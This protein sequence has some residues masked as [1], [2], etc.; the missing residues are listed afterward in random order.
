MLFNTVAVPYLKI[1]RRKQGDIPVLTH[2][3]AESDCPAYYPVFNTL[4]KKVLFLS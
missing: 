2:E 3:T 4:F 1:S